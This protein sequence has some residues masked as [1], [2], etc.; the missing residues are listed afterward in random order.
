MPSPILPRAAIFRVVRHP[1]ALFVDTALTF[2]RP[3]SEPRSGRNGRHRQRSQR[4]LPPETVEA[5]AMATNA[6]ISRKH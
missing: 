3:S 1:T 6:S 2:Q 5:Q 4:S